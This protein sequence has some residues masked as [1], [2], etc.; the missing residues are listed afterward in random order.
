VFTE[1]VVAPKYPADVL[2]FLKKK[3]DRRLMRTLKPLRSHARVEIKNVAGGVLLQTPDEIGLTLG[4][5]KVVTKRNPTE[6]ER[7]GMEFAWRVA[8]HVKSNAIVYAR[9][10]R[11]IGIGAG[12]TSRFD[13]SRIAVLK[14]RDAGLD[15]KETAVASDAFFPFADG[16]LE[17]VNAGA[18]AVIQPGGSIR[19]D[20]VIKAAD[21]NN[22]AMLF[23][24]IRHFKH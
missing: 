22:I 12:Q 11:T 1:V 3:K 20:E 17:A 15:L 19:D 18:T 23:T 16:L 2:E 24:G 4:Q 6:N 7:H 10:D 8:A 9:H 13:S 5:V 21:D 14:A